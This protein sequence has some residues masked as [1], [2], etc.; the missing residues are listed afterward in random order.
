M[1]IWLIS[2]FEQ[3]TIDKVFSTR[4]IS[5]A[6]E[7]L[8][9]GHQVH[10]FASTFKHNTKNQRFEETSHIEISKGY[11]LSFIKSNSYKR[12]IGVKRLMSHY[13]FGNDIINELDK[14]EKPDV[15]LMA[16]PP[17]HLTYKVSRW[18]KQHNVPVVMDIIDPWPD[19]FIK[20]FPNSLEFLGRIIFL[21]LKNKLSQTL[22]NVSG[23]SAISNQYLSWAQSH[24]SKPLEK[25]CFYPSTDL[26]SIQSKIDQIKIETKKSTNFENLTIIYAGSLASSYDIPCIIKAAELLEAEFGNKIIFKIAG[27]GP[28]ESVIKDYISNHNNLEYLGRLAKDD[29]LKQYYLSD[30]GLTQHKIGAS[31]SVTYKLFDLLSNGLPILNSLDSEMN[32]IIVDNKVGLFNQPGDFEKLADNIK[33]F[34]NNRE[35]LEEFKLNSIKLTE[36]LGDTKVVYANMVKFLEEISSKHRTH[37]S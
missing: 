33:F 3:T 5:I 11:K 32:S 36:K 8:K 16:F 34:Y 23:I 25:R 17:I 28:Q 27:V 30:L 13:H 35:V 24:L 12:N 18:A 7:A 19:I 2:I 21:P 31:Q 37:V 9:K 6:D 4:F 26:S 14:Y 22:N 10:F 1:N 20:A 29:L 15:I